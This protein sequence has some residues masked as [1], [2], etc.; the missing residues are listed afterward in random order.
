MAQSL[1]AQPPRESMMKPGDPLR[2]AARTARLDW[3]TEEHP[4]SAGEELQFA[5]AR[6]LDIEAE[7]ADVLGHV[8]EHWLAI[9]RAYL[10]PNP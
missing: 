8:K 5:I 6:L 9:A 4:G 1:G 3:A 2:R 10:G 7:R